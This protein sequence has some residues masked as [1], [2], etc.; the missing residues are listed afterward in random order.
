M[1]TTDD[2]MMATAARDRN[3]RNNLGQLS[4]LLRVGLFLPTFDQ[5]YFLDV[6][7]IISSF[8][9]YLP[10]KISNFLLSQLFKF[11]KTELQLF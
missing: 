11:D 6:H 7:F 10:C 8:H 9:S 1:A 3:F 5:F 2:D 4:E